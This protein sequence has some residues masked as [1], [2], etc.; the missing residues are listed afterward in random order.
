MADAMR[1]RAAT[2]ERRYQLLHDNEELHR[3]LVEA[4]RVG[5]RMVRV[6]GLR[7]PRT[8]IRR[9][10]GFGVCAGAAQN[11]PQLN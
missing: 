5:R 10:A 7:P 11:Q 2:L 1:E 6:G 9:G 3:R 8:P 4:Q